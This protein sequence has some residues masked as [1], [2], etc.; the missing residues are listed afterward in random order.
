M[1]VAKWV[2]GIIHLDFSFCY[3]N[4]RLLSPAL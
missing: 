4:T 1:N 2:I 3:M